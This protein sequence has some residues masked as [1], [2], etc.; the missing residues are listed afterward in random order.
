MRGLGDREMAHKVLDSMDT[1][2]QERRDSPIKA[3]ASALLTPLKV[4]GKTY[5]LN[6]IDTPGYVDFSIMKSVARSAACE[7]RLLVVDAAQGC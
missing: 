1:G 4:D 2:A 3:T 7:A 6:F 5:Q